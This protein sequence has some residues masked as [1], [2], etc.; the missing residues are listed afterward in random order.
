MLARDAVP[1]HMFVEILFRDQSKNYHPSWHVTHTAT[2]NLE[3]WINPFEA[4]QSHSKDL[5]CE[6]SAFSSAEWG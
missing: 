1:Y 6:T 5:I 3:P 4:V 2:A